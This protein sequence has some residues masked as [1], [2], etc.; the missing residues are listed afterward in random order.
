MGYI[1]QIS[2]NIFQKKHKATF[3]I[4][5]VVPM[6]ASFLETVD[7]GIRIPLV[8]YGRVINGTITKD[9]YARLGALRY[10]RVNA[11][12][13]EGFY[14]LGRAVED[15]EGGKVIIPDGNA[16]N[17]RGKIFITQRGPGI[18]DTKSLDRALPGDR[19]CLVLD[20]AKSNE[21][22]KGM[23]LEFLS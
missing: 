8:C 6:L 10:A 11:I 14:N 16:V 15:D 21:L 19:V 4:I 22:L 5:D 18:P 7:S 2:R 17:V 13:G 3:E 20:N 1:G 9:A 12:Y 23:K